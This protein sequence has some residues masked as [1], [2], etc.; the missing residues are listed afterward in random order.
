MDCHLL[1]WNIPMELTSLTLPLP[2]PHFLS[3]APS[4]P[5]LFIICSSLNLILSLSHP[6]PPLPSPLPSPLPF[7]SP[8]PL[9]PPSY[10]L[11]SILSHP[12][13][14]PP[15][16]FSPSPSS[17]VLKGTYDG[18]PVAVKLFRKIKGAVSLTRQY[19]SLREELTILSHL[20]HPRYVWNGME[21]NKYP[22]HNYA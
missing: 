10:P 19:K 4:L 6:S 2:L 1:P 18:H 14:P 11:Y 17:Q 15:L 7:S 5:S 16:P 13:P 12:L 3:P 21:T 22:Q 8:P 20:D 9:L